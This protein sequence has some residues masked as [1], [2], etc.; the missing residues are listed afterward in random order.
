MCCMRLAENTSLLQRHRSTEVNKTLHDV[1]PSPGLAHIYIFRGFCLLMEFCHVQNSLCVQVLC[2][3]MLAA[4]MHGT[5]AAGVSQT[6]WRGTRNGITELSQRAPPI[7]GWAAIMLGILR[8]R[9]GRW[10]RGSVGFIVGLICNHWQQWRVSNWQCAST[11]PL[12]YN[13]T[14]NVLLSLKLL[15]KRQLIFRL[16]I[17]C[18]AHFKWQFTFNLNSFMLIWLKEK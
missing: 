6:L 8:N 16:P 2:S 11:T 10:G 12:A 17:C 18:H 5:P 7:L 3:P 13:I 14:I 9:A 1:W 4:L 15:Y